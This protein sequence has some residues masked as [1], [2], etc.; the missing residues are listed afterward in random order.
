MAVFPRNRSRW[1][2]ALP[3][4]VS[5]LLTQLPLAVFAN[6]VV[7]GTFDGHDV[8][9]GTFQNTANGATTFTNSAGTGLFVGKDTTVRGVEVDANGALTNN[10][11]NLHFNAPGQV[12]QVDGTIDVRAAMNGNGAYLGHG[13]KVTID[14]AYLYQNGNIFANGLN[15]GTVVTNVGGLTVGPN[16]RIEAIATNGDAGKINLNSTGEVKIPAGAVIDASGNYLGGYNPNVIQIKGSIVNLDGVVMANGLNPGSHGGGVGVYGSEI[17]IGQNAQVTANGANGRAGNNFQHDGGNG[18]V[19]TISATNNLQND[20]LVSANGGHGSKGYNP[21]NGG[22]GGMVEAYAGKALY[23][24]GHLTANGGDGG[25]NHHVVSGSVNNG[26]QNSL[27]QDGGSGGN[28]GSV[29]L[30]FNTE[31]TNNGTIEVRGGNG[32]DGQAAASYAPYVHQIATGGNGGNGGTGGYVQFTGVPSQ[33][34]L[35]NVNISGGHG[36]QGGAASIK[37]DCGCATPGSKGACG[38]PGQIVIIPPPP[39]VCTGGSCSP[40]PTPPGTPPIPPLYPKEYPRLGDGLPPNAG[41]VLS[42]NRSIFLARAPLPIIQK[43]TPPAPPPP[44]AK[45]ML[46]KPKPKPKPIQKK[47]PVRGYW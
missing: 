26:Q 19:V 38:G 18:G 37:S 2:V 30:A 13:G 39:P 29:L 10:G 27:G 17:R 4:A 40:P 3:L 35:D 32:G 43:K 6:G 16:A 21:G 12:V 8:A 33:S 20:G 1:T 14:A 25:T 22:E 42:Y 15:G 45:V 36:G 31:M 24:N 46:V 47:V 9:G 11:G 34:V 23:N 5:L 7:N 41:N 28:G 44:P